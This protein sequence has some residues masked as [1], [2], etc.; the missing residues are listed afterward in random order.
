MYNINTM[1][2]MAGINKLKKKYTGVSTFAGCGGSSTGLK[3]ALVDVRYANEFVPVAADTYALNAPKTF[4]D[5][6]DIRL[7]KAKKILEICKLKKGE[8]DIFDGS[9]PCKGFSATQARKKG[10]EFGK[11][12]PYSEGIKQR[13]DDL[14]FEYAR[15]VKLIQPKIMIAENVD[16]LAKHVNRGMFIEIHDALTACGYQVEAKVIN[17]SFLGVPQAR[18]R[19][20]F[21]GVRNDI[22]KAGFKHVWPK[23]LAYET[24]VQSVL[25]HIVRVKTGKGYVD[26]Q[27][28][29]ATITASD[30]SIGESANFSCGG[31][32]ETDTGERRKYL[33]EELKTI[34]SFPQDFQ[35]IGTFNQQWERLGRSVP[36]LMHYHLGR[37]ITRGILDPYHESL[38]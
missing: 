11:V 12:V 26:S 17:A 2:S 15:L 23:P 37:A 6:E 38:K 35:L 24:S 21:M 18:K 3:M 25:P 13:V 1:P 16:G 7:V 31:F 32:I 34:F 5:R 27:N 4:V 14:F 20:I 9:P 10:N 19:I 29:S 8:L 30:H 33:I 22:Y 36:P 28:P